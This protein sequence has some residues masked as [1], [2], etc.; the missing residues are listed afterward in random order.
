MSK[1]ALLLLMAFITGS[2]MRP[3]FGQDT[4]NIPGVG[5]KRVLIPE[6]K[7]AQYPTPTMEFWREA[8]GAANHRIWNPCSWR[9]EAD[10]ATFGKIFYIVGV[11]PENEKNGL[12]DVVLNLNEGNSSYQWMEIGSVHDS[13]GKK[14]IILSCR[15]QYLNASW[16]YYFVKFASRVATNS[17]PAIDLYLVYRPVWIMTSDFNDAESR[18][19]K[20]LDILNYSDGGPPRNN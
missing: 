8:A 10:R 9:T 20:V 1:A 5:G 13:S 12:E 16:V 4:G 15:A 11:R 19:Q 2:F 14:L 7:L 18:M 17:Q 3:V 6:C